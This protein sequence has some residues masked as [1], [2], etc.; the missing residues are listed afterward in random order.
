MF[1]WSTVPL[2][3]SVAIIAFA[4]AVG[5]SYLYRL[6]RRDVLREVIDGEVGA[7]IESEYLRICIRSVRR[8]IASKIRAEHCHEYDQ[9]GTTNCVSRSNFTRNRW[10]FLLC[11][12]LD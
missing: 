10:R 5:L 3:Q 11:A 7:E 12:K 4:G 8:Q 6:T 2:E 9:V 1:E